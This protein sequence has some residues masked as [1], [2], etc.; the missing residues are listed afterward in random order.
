MFNELR[1]QLLGEKYEPKEFVTE[2]YKTRMKLTIKSVTAEDYGT[3]KCLSRNA[4][5]DTDGTIK[6]YLKF[7][8][9][10]SGL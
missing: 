6:I 2:Q 4:L 8:K 10:K 9:N 5:G 1:L 3:Y 7:N